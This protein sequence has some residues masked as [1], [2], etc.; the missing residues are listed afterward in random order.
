M[1]DD[2]VVRTGDS[3]EAAVEKV[4]GTMQSMAESE[5]RAGAQEL[6]DNLAAVQ[7]GACEWDSVNVGKLKA[8]GRE[9][10]E[11]QIPAAYV[12]KYVVMVDTNTRGRVKADATGYFYQQD[13]EFF[14]ATIDQTAWVEANRTN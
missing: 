8:Y 3:P 2:P 4:G 7:M 6:V 13:G 5:D 11:D 12:C 10:M 1:P 9:R 14:Q